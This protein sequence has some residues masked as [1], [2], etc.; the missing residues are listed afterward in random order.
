MVSDDR[1]LAINRSV[2]DIGIHATAQK[3][4]IKENS[5][6]R[7]LR[8]V[9]RIS[10]TNVKILV[11]DIETS[12][13]LAFVWYTGK[14]YVRHDNIVVPT[15][16]LSWSAKWL[17]DT[18]VFGD[19]VRPDEA[20][21]CDDERIVR[22]LWKALDEADIVIAHNGDRFD[23][24][25][26]NT[27]FLFYDMIPPS[28]YNSIDTYQVVRK[29]RTGFRMDSNKLDFIGQFLLNKQKIETNFS[30]W[31]RCHAGEKAALDEMFRYNKR[32][33][34]LLE[35][36]YYRLRPWIKSHPNLGLYADGEVCPSC[37]SKSISWGGYYD[38]PSGRY[39]A[40]RCIDCGS[41]GR[42]RFTALSAEQRKSLTT[43]TAR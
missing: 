27:R 26:A 13:A 37:G 25:V 41:I 29:G 3:F 11:F 1:I 5:L 7:Y 28:P 8:S 30:L 15:F 14:Q 24:P 6:K 31:K 21:D 9:K 32:D 10:R 4:K 23:I 34:V 19:I 16:M 38:T 17:N 42:S 36:V 12:P 33:V 39:S 20:R 18:S 22:S 2:R 35:E 43:S 40:F